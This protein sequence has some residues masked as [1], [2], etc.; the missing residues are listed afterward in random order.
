M[1]RVLCGT[2]SRPD[3]LQAP[4]IVAFLACCVVSMLFGAFNG[5]LVAVFK[6]QPMVAT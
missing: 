1:L 2:N 4:I 3:T 5:T 6:I